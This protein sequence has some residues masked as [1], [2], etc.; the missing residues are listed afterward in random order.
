MAA[1]IDK[2]IRSPLPLRVKHIRRPNTFR[3]CRYRGMWPSP[4]TIVTLVW[5][6]PSTIRSTP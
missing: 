3:P 4:S 6:S 5:S 2:W 1:Y